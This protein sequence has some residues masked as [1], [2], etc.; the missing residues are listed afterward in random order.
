MEA[1]QKIDQNV[2]QAVP[3]FLVTDM[4][5]SVRF[6][7]EGLGFKMTHQW[8]VDEKL[9]WCWLELG[10]AAMM[11]Q[12]PMREGPDA[13]IL[14]AGLGE[15]VSINF[16]C[17]DA[18]EIYHRMTQQRIE[19]RRPFVGNSNWEVHLKDPDGYNLV[20]VSHTDVPE[21]TLYNG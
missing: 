1:E 4:A 18:L 9:R 7:I 17:R 14:P 10:G 3:F 8:V 20:F 15:G 12:E 5:R 21:E 11:L 16:T 6:Y 2:R 13:H 19:V